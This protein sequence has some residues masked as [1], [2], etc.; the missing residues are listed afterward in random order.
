MS[1]FPE[2]K[3]LAGQLE[4]HVV[5]VHLP[6]KADIDWESTEASK[7]IVLKKGFIDGHLA[8]IQSSDLILIANFPK[9]GIEGYIGPN[10]L[11]EIAFAWALNKSVVLL[12]DPGP[13]DCRFEVLSIADRIIDGD[14]RLLLQGGI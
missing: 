4:E 13:Q 3:S 10:T 2:M 12:F 5:R 1:S 7:L 6:Q 11:M 9:K 14:F 8:K